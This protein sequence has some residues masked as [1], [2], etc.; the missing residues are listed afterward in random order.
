[1]C[2]IGGAPCDTDDEG[3]ELCA[4]LLIR[5]ATVITMDEANPRA[6]AL[7]VRDGRILLAGTEEAARAAVGPGAVEIDA[8]GRTVLPGFIDP[9]NHLL[10]TAESLAALDARYPTVTS[11]ADLVAAVAAAAERTPPGQW[12]RAFGMDDAKYPEG[13]PTRRVLDEATTEHPVDHLP[14][15]RAPGGGQLCRARAERGHR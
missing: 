2:R 10:S 1:M 14:R 13:R 6:A 15:F 12:I 7:A 11:V 8:G 9:H 5:N 4:A 3:V